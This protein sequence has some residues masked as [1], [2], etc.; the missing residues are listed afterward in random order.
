[1]GTIAGALLIVV[2]GIVDVSGATFPGTLIAIAGFG[3]ILK[4]R[5]L[6]ARRRNDG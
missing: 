1:V 6:P 3:L 2:G 4:Y 5:I